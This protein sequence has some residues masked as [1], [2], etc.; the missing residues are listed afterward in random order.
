[1]NDAARSNLS[2]KLNGLI[3]D[4]TLAEKIIADRG[5][6][7][8]DGDWNAISDAAIVERQNKVGKIKERIAAVEKQISELA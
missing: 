7:D 1:M 6:R 5:F 2:R 8:A 4:L 3:A